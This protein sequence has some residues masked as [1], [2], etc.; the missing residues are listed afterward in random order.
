MF[1]SEGSRGVPVS[2]FIPTAGRIWFLQIQNWDPISF[3]SSSC[4]SDNPHCLGYW[5]L[6]TLL[7]LVMVGRDCP[8]VLVVK[9][10]SANAG[11]IRDAGSIPE[12]RRS[13]REG[14]G[15]PLQY[16]VWR[17]PWTEEP[18]RLQSMGSQRVRHDCS[19]L[20]MVSEVLL[21]LWIS[22]TCLSIVTHLWFIFLPSSSIAKGPCNYTD[23]I[24]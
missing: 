7:Q 5:L 8:M 13:P 16:L 2:L 4:F 6:S 23:P 3:L 19:N 21:T 10:T 17:I 14:N 11:D 22:H 12:S 9:N 1:R 24:N 18:D 20:A 15:N